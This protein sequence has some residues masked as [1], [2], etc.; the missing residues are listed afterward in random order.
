MS[1]R[2]SITMVT[3]NSA[4]FLER[5]LETV[6]RLEY[7]DL[8]VIV[9]DNG[10]ADSTRALLRGSR[11]PSEV[12]FNTDNRG[13]AAAQN[14]AIGKSSG[15]IV[16]VLNPDTLLTPA[17]VGEGLRGFAVGART[18]MVAPKLVRTT[19]EFTIPGAHEARIDSAG[20]FLASSLRHFD[21]GAGERDVGQ[22]DRMERV[23]GPSGAAALYSRALIED[24]KVGG[25]FFDELF[26]AYREDADLA[27]RARLFAWECVYVP[28]ALAYHM[29][30]VRPELGRNVPAGINRHSVKN[31]FLMRIKNVTPDVY[32]RVLVPTT[33]RDL[34]VVAGTVL[35][36]PRSVP[37]LVAV[38]RNL[39]PVLRARRE[40]QGRRRHSVRRW[41]GRQSMPL[42]RDETCPR[43]SSE[44]RGQGGGDAAG[45][46]GPGNATLVVGSGSVRSRLAASAPRVAG[47]YF[48]ID[49]HGAERAGEGNSTYSQGLIAA[50]LG[51]SG[52]D[53]FALFAGDPRHTFYASLPVRGRSR[54]I[55]VPQGKGLARL[56]WTLSRAAARE[57]VD[58]LHVQYT[59][60]LGYRG[61]L[62]VTV[63]DLGFLHVPGSFP[64]GLRVA[65][66]VLVPRSI[67]RASHVIT[68][69]E[70]SRRDIVARYGVRRE[71]IAVIPL[72]ADSRFYPRTRRE[73]APV[74]ARYGLE[75]GF[76]FSLGRLNRR[77]NLER[78]LLAYARLR[79]GIARAT[80][81]VVG[82]KPDYGVEEMLS[83]SRLSGE[84]SG[85][86]F[87][88]LIPDEDLPAFYAG[89]A[90]FVYPSLFEGFGLPLLEAMASGTPVVTSDR[91]ALPELIGD[92]ALA[93]DPESVDAL[94]DAMAR[95]MTD[96]K[97]ARDLRQRG[98][99]R[100]RQFSWTETAR[101]TLAVYREACGRS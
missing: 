44:D 78:L 69:S 28:R 79:S 90:G 1:V 24:V 9:V 10:S 26:F 34:M 41:V 99:V 76:L 83:R 101:R 59:A 4:R 38:V 32:A 75:P 23:F 81:L 72:A 86:R 6:E 11:V 54:A 16:L 19:E 27:W 62:V 47:M 57:R 48:G 77:K 64:L 17:F 61:P 42:H 65:L 12:L 71:K 18:G 68:D 2:V 37:G 98:L 13:F 58:G 49:A 51:S 20:M 39:G 66:R 85:V 55:H 95:M 100:S 87:V 35:L 80:P 46:V 43:A 70:F 73:T 50:L 82:G 45:P 67:V 97:L 91:A 89:A 21:R 30:R 93:V 22:Y 53:D 63:H 31:R 29:R 52:V 33:V 15:D 36:E 74:L 88:G 40:I 5:C 94:A 14:Q 60:P 92:A 96:A 56:G 25:E 84:A 7:R 8:E 3:W